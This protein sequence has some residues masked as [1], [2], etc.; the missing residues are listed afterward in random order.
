MAEEEGF[1]FARYEGGTCWHALVR[2]TGNIE[3][4]GFA[5]SQHKRCVSL[6]LI[7]PL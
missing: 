7:R 3:T 6:I 1:Y 2:Y 4:N 5:L